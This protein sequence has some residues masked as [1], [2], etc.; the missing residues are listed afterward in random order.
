ML[1]NDDWYKLVAASAA[2]G[3]PFRDQQR[4][5]AADARPGR[6]CHSCCERTCLRPPHTHTQSARM[7]SSLSA[8]YSRRT[9]QWDAAQCSHVTQCRWQLAQTVV[10]QVQQHQLEPTQS[11]REFLHARC[12]LP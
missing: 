10:G 2:G 7:I 4:S 1:N 3:V 5:L 9:H 11:I 6:Q 8:P 12:E